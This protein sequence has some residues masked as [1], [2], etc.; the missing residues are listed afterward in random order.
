MFDLV[1][2]A[3]AFGIA[4]VTALGTW[5]Y[6]DFGTGLQLALDDAAALTGATLD[7]TPYVATL[8]VANAWVPIQEFIVLLLLWIVFAWVY[9]VVKLVIK[10]IPTVG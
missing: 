9:I 1:K 5:V 10:L 8:E 6:L 7:F 3:G 4:L 2:N